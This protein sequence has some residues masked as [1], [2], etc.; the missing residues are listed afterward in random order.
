MHAPLDCT[1]TDDDDLLYCSN[2]KLEKLCQRFAVRRQ[3]KT[4]LLSGNLGVSAA[5]PQLGMGFSTALQSRALRK[6]LTEVGKKLLESAPSQLFFEPELRRGE[7]ALIRAIAKCGTMWPWAGTPEDSQFRHVVWW[8]G[9]TAS[10]FLLMYGD[11]SNY[12]GDDWQQAQDREKA[13]WW[14][15]R[16]DAYL[17]LIKAMSNSAL[18]ADWVGLAPENPSKSTVAG[19]H[20]SCF[21]EGVLRGPLLHNSMVV[22]SLIRIDHI[23]DTDN[24]REICG[25]PLWVRRVRKPVPGVYRT[26]ETTQVSVNDWF[27]S[28]KQCSSYALA[29]W[30]GNDW[31]NPRWSPIYLSPRPCFPR[32]TPN[33]PSSDELPDLNN[34]ER[35]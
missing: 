28:S 33:L 29:D 17:K 32:G 30:D 2:G 34:I 23:E 1:V 3:G 6:L 13:T 7:F 14:P 5:G 31:S 16:S 10:S 8:T 19:L 11:L 21:D 9:Q 25:S 15:S 22:E 35:L 4:P 27:T 12:L 26:G 20:A 18:S 24:H